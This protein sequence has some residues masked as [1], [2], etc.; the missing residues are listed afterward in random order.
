MQWDSILALIGFITLVTFL[1][2][3]GLR[4]TMFGQ[5]TKEEL[6]KFLLLGGTF[7]F[8]IGVYWTLR[9]MKDSI[10]MSM[11]GKDNIPWAKLVSLCVLF[12]LVIIY[13]K[14]VDKF[15]RHRM[16]YVMAFLYAVA[17]ILFAFLLM[18]PT[19]GLPNKAVESSRIVG[20]AWYVFV[21]SYGS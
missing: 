21:E 3:P 6:K 1:S 9:P 20:W 18:H 15:P 12:P 2:V 5:F 11:V 13:S 17:T 14:L 7:I 19:L 10:F 16:L 4:R 8:L